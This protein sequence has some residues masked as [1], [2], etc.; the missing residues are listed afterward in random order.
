MQAYSPYITWEISHFNKL[1]LQFTHTDRDE[2]RSN[3]GVFLQWTWILG[4]H[5]HGFSNR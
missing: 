2:L 1:R 4:A 3:D 5:A